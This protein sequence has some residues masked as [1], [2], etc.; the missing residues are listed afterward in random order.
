MG[1]VDYIS[2]SALG[3]IR[4]GGEQVRSSGAEPQGEV[5]RG[6]AWALWTTFP[7]V[8][9]VGQMGRLEIAAQFAYSCLTE[10]D[11]HSHLVGFLCMP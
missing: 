3:V 4:D 5:I 8:L 1:S 7:R 10:A 2:Q 6:G 11:L 9:C